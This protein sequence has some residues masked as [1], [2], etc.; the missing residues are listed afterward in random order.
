MLRDALTRRATQATR[1]H[2]A[3]GGAAHPASFISTSSAPR[4]CCG[5]ATRLWQASTERTSALSAMASPPAAR[6]SSR[7]C[8]AWASLEFYCTATRAPCAAK[9]LATAAPM[10]VDAP[11][12][13][14]ALQARSVIRMGR[15][16][17]DATNQRALGPASDQLR[18][19]TTAGHQALCPSQRRR[20]ARAARLQ[21]ERGS[22]HGGAHE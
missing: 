1:G 2:E 8:N 9:P 19:A 17:R 5:S 12:M 6:I 20:P 18:P 14:T 16:L 11:V 7:T 4:R 13:R 15:I 21:R 22:R 10:P 3:G